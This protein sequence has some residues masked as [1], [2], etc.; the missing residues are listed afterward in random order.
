MSLR[1][2]IQAALGE[3]ETAG[4]TTKP[5]PYLLATF[6]FVVLVYS[7]NSTV[8]SDAPY[9]N[10]RQLFELTEERAKQV[11]YRECRSLLRN[12]FD[13]HP[14]EPAQVITDYGH[15]TV[16]PPS[17]ANEIRSDPKLSFSEFSIDVGL[18]DI[19][20]HRSAARYV[21]WHLPLMKFFQ[22]Q[23]PGFEAPFQGTKD[24]LTLTVI[25]KDLTK[26]LGQSQKPRQLE[27]H[28]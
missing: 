21:N 12:W 7:L 17:M 15:M 6:V 14:N 28:A 11:Y 20:I 13:S 26:F 8:K 9:L 3:I 1:G 23:Y 24:F 5:I 16:L 22:T 4:I 10:P 27:K 18:P 19:C 2:S 25:N